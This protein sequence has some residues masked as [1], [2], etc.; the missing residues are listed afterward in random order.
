MRVCMHACVRSLSG[1]GR[2]EVRPNNWWEVGL[3][4]RCDVGDWPKQ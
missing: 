2:L 4:N 1:N 3:R